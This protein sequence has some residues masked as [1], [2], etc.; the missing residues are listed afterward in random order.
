MIIKL[1]GSNCSN[2]LKQKKILERLVSNSEYKIDLD[3]VDDD[4]TVKRLNIINK[5]GL[6]IN[7]VL[8]S[9]GKIQTDRD[10][11]KYLKLIES[12]V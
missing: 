6:I 1:I 2:G 12:N 4:K 9:Q 3:I 11:L 8:V 5:P 10:I 7:N